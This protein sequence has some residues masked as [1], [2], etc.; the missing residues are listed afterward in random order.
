M[1]AVMWEDTE[2]QRQNAGRR[3]ARFGGWVS[4]SLEATGERRGDQGVVK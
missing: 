3:E 4:W 1:D 2:F